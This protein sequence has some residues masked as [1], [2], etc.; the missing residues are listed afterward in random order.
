MS[1]TRHHFDVFGR[2]LTVER[3][4]GAWVVY[5]PTSDG[6]RRPAEGV[7]IP[8]HVPETELAGY[9]ADLCHEWADAEHPEVRRL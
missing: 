2:R 5:A 4:R 8:P 7:V 1:A 6:K 3:R 9:L